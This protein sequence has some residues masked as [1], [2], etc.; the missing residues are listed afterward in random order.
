[1]LFQDLMNALPRS[2]AALFHG[3]LDRIV[4]GPGASRDDVLA[5]LQRVCVVIES[6]LDYSDYEKTILVEFV[7]KQL[8]NA[9]L[10]ALFPA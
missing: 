6:Q 3:E 4:I 2:V 7:L 1:M 9:A 8:P 5:I 10:D